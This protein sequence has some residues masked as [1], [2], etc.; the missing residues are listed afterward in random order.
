VAVPDPFT[1]MTGTVFR[2]AERLL[3][4]DDHKIRIRGYKVEVGAG[5]LPVD[6]DHFR[7]EVQ[8][9]TMKSIM[10]R[11]GYLKKFLIG[12]YHIPAGV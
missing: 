8:F 2:Q 6:I 12:L 10:K 5:S 7:G 3:I 4:V 11:L 9:F 1:V